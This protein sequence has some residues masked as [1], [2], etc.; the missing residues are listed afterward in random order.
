MVM[1]SDL[2][3]LKDHESKIIEILDDIIDHGFGEITINV[4]ETKRCET[5]ILIIAGRSWVFF[6]KKDTHNISHKD[7]L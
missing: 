4:G 2:R 7:I 3:Q 1:E 5:K 6:L